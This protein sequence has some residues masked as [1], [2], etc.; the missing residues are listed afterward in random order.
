MSDGWI[1]ET[2][3]CGHNR[4]AHRHEWNALRGEMNTA[5]TV[6]DR[7]R[8]GEPRCRCSAFTTKETANA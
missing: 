4:S 8:P 2:E 3:G 1:C 7:S 6:D 5:C